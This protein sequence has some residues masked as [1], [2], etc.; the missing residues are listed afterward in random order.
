M[1]E[2][3]PA[4]ALRWSGVAARPDPAAAPPIATPACGRRLLPPTLCSSGWPWARELPVG[5]HVRAAG[6]AI[7]LRQR[8]ARTR[9]LRRRS[10]RRPAADVCSHGRFVPAD[11]HGLGNCR[12]ERTSAQRAWRLRCGTRPAWTRRLRRR[13]RRRPAAGTIS[14]WRMAWI[15]EDAVR[16]LHSMIGGADG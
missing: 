7:T 4:G 14:H 12:W 6:V 2:S 15:R 5:A 13:S 1:G 3:A 11:G 10:L 16:E 8:P 9:R